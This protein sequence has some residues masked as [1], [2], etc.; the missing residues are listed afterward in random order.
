RREPAAI[1]LLER[2]TRLAARGRL[3]LQ[4]RR[5]PAAVEAVRQRR[6]PGPFRPYDAQ[7]HRVPLIPAAGHVVA[8]HAILRT[9]PR[10]AEPA[11]EGA[12]RRRQ[13]TQLQQDFEPLGAPALRGDHDAV[14]FRFGQQYERVPQVFEARIDAA[15]VLP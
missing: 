13:R 3:E 15:V 6:G 9:G 11:A 2:D 4:R 5:R 8:F 12:D 1:A 14:D 10:V 7:V